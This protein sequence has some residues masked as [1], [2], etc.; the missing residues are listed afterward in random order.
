MEESLLRVMKRN[1]LVK[2]VLGPVMATSDPA[3]LA[4]A[5]NLLTLIG[6]L[7]PET[8]GDASAFEALRSKKHLADPLRRLTIEITQEIVRGDCDDLVAALLSAEMM[9]GTQHEMPPVSAGLLQASPG[10]VLLAAIAG[11]S[12]LVDFSSEDAFIELREFVTKFPDYPDIRDIDRLELV[13]QKLCDAAIDEAP[14]RWP[15]SVDASGLV[16]DALRPEITSHQKIWSLLT[17]HRSLLV[18]APLPVAVSDGEGGRVYAQPEYVFDPYC[19]WHPYFEEHLATAGVDRGVARMV[20]LMVR[21]AGSGDELLFRQLRSMAKGYSPDM[22]SPAGTE[23]VEMLTFEA[24]MWC[25]TIG[26]WGLTPTFDVERELPPGRISSMFGLIRLFREAKRT[27]ALPHREQE[28][29][30]P[31]QRAR[32][33][34]VLDTLERALLNEKDSLYDQLIR[35]TKGRLEGSPIGEAQAQLLQR[36]QSQEI[37]RLRMWDLAAADY[38]EL[39]LTLDETDP[40]TKQAQWMRILVLRLARF[41]LSR[42]RLTQVEHAVE[43]EQ[44]LQNWVVTMSAHPGTKQFLQQLAKNWGLMIGDE[45]LVRTLRSFVE[46]VLPYLRSEPM[47]PG[48]A[49]Q[50]R[51]E[52]L[53]LTHQRSLALR[54]LVQRHK[55]SVLLD[56][57]PTGEAMHR[58]VTATDVQMFGF[59]GRSPEVAAEIYSPWQH[60]MVGSSALGP[61]DLKAP[62]GWWDLWGQ[63]VC[64]Y[65]C[66]DTALH[67]LVPQGG[68]LVVAPEK[69]WW[70]VPYNALRDL[71]TGE[72]LGLSRDLYLSPGGFDLE[73]SPPVESAIRALV[74]GV[75]DFSHMSPDT[76]DPMLW[77]RPPEDRLQPLPLAEAEAEWVAK[78]YGDG[79]VH[80]RPQEQT[81]RRIRM[82][83][84]LADI[85]HFAS[86][87]EQPSG[88]RLGDRRCQDRTSWTFVAGEARAQ[89]SH[90]SYTVFAEDRDGGL[91]LLLT[92]EVHLAQL[93]AKVVVLSGCSTFQTTFVHGAPLAAAGAYLSAGAECVVAT[94]WPIHDEAAFI[95]MTEFHCCLLSGMTVARAARFGR[96]AVAGDPRFRSPYYWAPFSVVGKGMARLVAGGS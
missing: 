75:S 6:G 80:L 77:H 16:L 55:G 68:N 3:V 29:W 74:A 89:L 79:A 86:H 39:L 61:E 40:E 43:V 70:D 58:Y 1:P 78:I 37:H 66:P 91:N 18:R 90:H 41:A 42:N 7:V 46:S 84:P 14:D 62:D 94:L 35:V 69:E 92:K 19:R 48:E 71:E 76:I 50:L 8:Q 31:R 2:A 30:Q 34:L 81:I 26:T 11:Q 65:L 93:K 17:I 52:I 51:S 21:A 67:Q 95:F 56:L 57:C 88:I 32:A 36:S 60:A 10:D 63:R 87:H 4:R 64:K 59:P 15:A 82:E 27:L 20:M 5:V 24:S 96:Q 83:L 23:I 28:T 54:T 72:A 25:T 73:P 12:G 38:L 44:A 85:I 47:V 13:F 45:R 33:L 49:I 22:S 9:Q 53:K